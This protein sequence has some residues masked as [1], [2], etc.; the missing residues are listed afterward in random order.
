VNEIPDALRQA[1]LTDDKPAGILIEV[2][3]QAA[4]VVKAPAEDV[5]SFRGA[6]VTYQYILA[7]YEEGPVLCLTLEILDDP[8]RPF[9]IETFLDVTKPEDLALAEKLAGQSELALH[10]YD[11]TLVYQ[12]TKTFAHRSR[13]R[14]ALQTLIERA[15]EHLT[16]V[17]EPNWHAARERFLRQVAW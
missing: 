14:R 5:R 3:D 15:A 4:V 7:L 17:V 10:F 8:E 13:Q 12:F 1:L 6:P 2:N 16:T 11:P 9:G